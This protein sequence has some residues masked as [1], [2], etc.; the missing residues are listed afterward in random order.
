MTII[1]ALLIVIVG[2]F[3]VWS[4]QAVID[5]G[6]RERN[7]LM[8]WLMAVAP[9]RW[10]VIKVGVHIAIAVV[11]VVFDH[12]AVTIGGAVFGAMIGVVVL[13]NLYV[14]SKRLLKS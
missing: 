4:T 12:G 13:W 6:G 8:K 2:V 9:K 14:F 11:V 10:V 3:D 7:P 5:N 1:V